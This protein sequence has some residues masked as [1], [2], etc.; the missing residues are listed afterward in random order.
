MR[1][2]EGEGEGEGVVEAERMRG[3]GGRRDCHGR[4]TAPLLSAER[5]S[6]PGAQ[7]PSPPA[8]SCVSFQNKRENS[9]D[10]SQ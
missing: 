1:E 9:K 4:S 2:G 3:G 7:E 5:P 6:G 10:V 8:A